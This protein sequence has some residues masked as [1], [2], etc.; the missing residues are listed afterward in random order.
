MLNLADALFTLVYVEAGVATEAN[1]LMHTAL[2]ESPVAFMAV[3]L[4]LVS[5][6]VWL[7]WRWR[8]RRSAIAGLVTATTAYA[9]LFV[10]HVSA[11]TRFVSFDA[12]AMR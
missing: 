10:Y 8:T 6:G 12:I 4:A 11:A 5:L 7:L 2:R 9:S 1:P 3:K